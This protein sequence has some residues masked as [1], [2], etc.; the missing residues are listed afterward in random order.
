MA[1]QPSRPP[2]TDTKAR[3]LIVFIGFLL[4][5]IGGVSIVLDLIGI[6]LAFLLWLEYFGSTPAFI[7]KIVMMMAGIVMALA[8]RTDDEVYDEF[9]D[10][11]SK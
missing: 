9:F 2:Q 6:K 3:N 4:L 11:E 5:M 10:K 7:I 1:K 8:A